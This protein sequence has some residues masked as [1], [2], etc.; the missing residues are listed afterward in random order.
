MPFDFS[1]LLADPTFVYGMSLLG[2]R[3]SKNPYMDAQQ[4]AMGIQEFQQKQ[5]LQKAKLEAEQRRQNFD[6]T[7]YRTPGQ[8]AQPAMPIGLGAFAEP[9]M[10]EPTAATPESFDWTQAASDFLKAGGDLSD[11]AAFKHYMTQAAPHKYAAIGGN[12]MGNLETGEFLNNPQAQENALARITEQGQIRKD[13][14]ELKAKLR[15]PTTVPESIIQTPEGVFSKPRGGAVQQLTMPGTTKPLT[16]TPTGAATRPLPKNI[17]NQIQED[18]NIEMNL[19]GALTSFKPAFGNKGLVGIGADA[20]LEA[21]ARLGIDQE[22]VSWWK[23]LRKNIDMVERKANFGATLTGNELQAWR[24]ATVSPKDD[25]ETIKRNLGIRAALAK[26]V[27]QM[28]TQD[29]MEA[30]PQ[31]AET[32]SK[33]G[34]RAKA[35]ATPRTPQ[36]PAGWSFNP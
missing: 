35:P 19:D 4:A 7:K 26:K 14:E 12:A 21:S 36:L 3:G 24:A 17:I 8:P 5:A 25:S 18:R 15:P 22:A 13:L 16:K 2:S 11:M 31:H 23:N 32:I 34:G 33:I 9:R 29:Y 1:K 20:Q 10:T 28:D 30:M 6:L 27:L